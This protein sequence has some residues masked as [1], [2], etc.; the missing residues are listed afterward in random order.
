MHTIQQCMYVRY[1]Q[2]HVQFS[3][4]CHFRNHKRTKTAE[5]KAPRDLEMTSEGLSRNIP[6]SH[7]EDHVY[8]SSDNPI[9]RNPRYT[10]GMT[11]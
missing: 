11:K 4:L 6:L 10:Y 9:Q 5:A 7:A 8:A 3:V 2:Q 1:S